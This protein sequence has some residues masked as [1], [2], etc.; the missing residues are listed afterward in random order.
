M[1]VIAV[2]TALYSTFMSKSLFQ[3]RFRRTL[4]FFAPFFALYAIL[5]AF[6]PSFVGVKNTVT[7]FVAIAFFI[8]GMIGAR[9]FS[10]SPTCG[11]LFI[12]SSLCF[13]F[14]FTPITE[15]PKN[16][17]SGI[18][19]YSALV[20]GSILAF[21]NPRSN[22]PALI[23][24]GV[25]ILLG[26]HLDHRMGL[27]SGLAGII[28]YI[29]VSYL[30]FAMIRR[31]ILYSVIFS[32]VALIVLYSGIGGFNIRDYNSYVVELTGRT[33][34][35]GRQIIW[36]IIID[37]VSRSQ[38]IG[39]GTGVNFSDLYVSHWSAHSIF[40]QIYMQ[41]GA[42]GLLLFIG[43]LFGVWK[44]IGRPEKRNNLSAY[45]NATF[46]V[47]LLHSSTEVFLTQVNLPIGTMAWLSLG[48]CVGLLQLQK[49]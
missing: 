49:K 40:M 21:R 23:T 47:V 24:F 27:A 41:V 32:I 10:R 8:L 43:V 20:G 30:P 13:V 28:I 34:S 4:Y 12:A 25:I 6:Q 31:I 35:S 48:L 22:W 14:I 11:F 38:L 15:V 3:P 16:T 42:L 1:I 46:I 44:A 5:T 33:A 19:I 9:N 17:V 18:S 45:A 2:S 29:T 7:L 37:A 39:L 26:I 36:P